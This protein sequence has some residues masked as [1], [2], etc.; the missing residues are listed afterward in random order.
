MSRLGVLVLLTAGALG[1][2]GQQSLTVTDYAD[3]IE[4]AT[5][6]YVTESQTLSQTFQDTV[7]G[8]VAKIIE[9]SSND[10]I[11]EVTE[12]TKREIV[13]YLALLEDTM[14]RYED[15]L[16]DIDPPSDLSEAHVAYLDAVTSVRMALPLTRRSVESAFDLDR[17][18]GAL[19]GSGFQDG[20]PRLTS[21]CQVLERSVRSLGR[22]VD[23]GCVRPSPIDAGR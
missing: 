19:A 20:Q 4:A 16:S 7:D 17:I 8:E 12:L 14:A 21:T 13:L 18:Y 10:R 9:S 11:G 6:G 3:Q 2:C 15:L 23:L 5:D 1:A 22:G